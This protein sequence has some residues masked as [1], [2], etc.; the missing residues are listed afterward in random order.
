MAVFAGAVTLWA[1]AA[2]A[3]PPSPGVCQPLSSISFK[4]PPTTVS[5]TKAYVIYNNLKEPRGMRMDGEQNLLVVER[6]VGVSALTYRNDTTCVGWE[7]RVVIE[8]TNLEHGIEI[9]PGKGNS[10]YLYA[11]SME[12]VFRWEYN[13][14][15]ATVIGSP[16]TLVFNMSNVGAIPPD[17]VTRT[18]LLESPVGGVSKSLI[19]SRGSAGNVD[20]AAADVNT[21]TAQIR[22]FSLTNVPAGT[23]WQWQ[24]G[25]ILG[26]GNRNGVGIAFSK[27]ESNI[28]EIENSSDEVQWRGVDVHQ[29]NPAEELNLIPLK[30]ANTIPLN[31]KFYGYPTCFTAWDSSTVPKNASGPQFTFKTGDQFSNQNPQTNITD[32]W[33]GDAKNNVPPKLS[34]QAHTAPLDIIFYQNSKC[35]FGS[36]RAALPKAWDGDAFV[37]LH[38]SWNRD[39]PVGYGVVRI[40]WS[41]LGDSPVAGPKV[42]NGYVNVV[43]VPDFS[44]CPEECIRPVSMV[45]DR[46]GR[47]IVSSDDSGEIFMVEKSG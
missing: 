47:M 36:S 27:D 21:G 12:N 41:K 16:V 1:A 8:N 33:C 32:A 38:G 6:N 7:K 39:A 34:L 19:V 14:K 17:H 20:P 40:P 26:W 5:G 18:L 46:Y 44:K 28:W 9:G 4:Y 23:G 25:D 10:Q 11:S 43:S 2:L 29:D 35:A 24:R 31:R 37:S 15:T 22:R 45:V 3:A 30:G 13:P 42:K